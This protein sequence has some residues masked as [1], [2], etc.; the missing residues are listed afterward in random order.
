VRSITPRTDLDNGS[1]QIERREHPLGSDKERV[2]VRA[3]NK[4]ALHP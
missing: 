2:N 4:Y 3:V 1:L